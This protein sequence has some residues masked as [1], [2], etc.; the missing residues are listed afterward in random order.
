MK[1]RIAFLL[2]V[3]LLC[4]L[5]ASLNI[6]YMPAGGLLFISTCTLDGESFTI[7]QKTM[8]DGTKIAVYD[9]E[10]SIVYAKYRGLTYTSPKFRSLRMG[11]GCR[12]P[13]RSTAVRTAL[14]PTHKRTASECDFSTPPRLFYFIP[15]WKIQFLRRYSRPR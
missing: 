15:G 9:G 14:P 5:A 8:P 11:I 12:S 2:I 6:S 10:T 13:L 3:P 4:V 1:K 7:R